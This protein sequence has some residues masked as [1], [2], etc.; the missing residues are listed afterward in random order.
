MPQRACLSAQAA[1]LCHALLTVCPSARSAFHM[2]T[3]QPTPASRASRD[4]ATARLATTEALAPGLAPRRCIAR[5]PEAGS[6]PCLLTCATPDHSHARPRPKSLPL[7]ELGPLCI[8]GSS[9]AARDTHLSFAPTLS[10]HA[11]FVTPSPV[12][13]PLTKSF[14]PH[15][16]PSWQP[17]GLIVFQ[18][19]QR[20]KGGAK[21]SRQ[22]GSRQ[23]GWSCEL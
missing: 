23:R 10:P 12:P 19:E 17:T 18:G 14:V 15:L 20:G 6:A 4:G 1:C 22:R 21:R 3:R 13:L 2:N 11:D 16:Q 5:R 8:G 7:L 9:A